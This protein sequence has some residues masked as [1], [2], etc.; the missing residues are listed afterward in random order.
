MSPWS[1]PGLIGSH[2]LWSA[3]HD[4]VLGSLAS[5]PSGLGSDDARARLAALGPNSIHGPRGH[6]GWR[7]LLAQFESPMVLILV[8][9]TLVLMALGGVVDGSVNTAVDAAKQ[10]AAL[11]LLDK[12]LDVVSDAVR[13]GRQTVAN[14]LTYVRVTVSANFGNMLSMAAAISGVGAC[15]ASRSISLPSSCTCAESSLVIDATRA[16]SAEIRWSR[17][18]AAAVTSERSVVRRTSSVRSDSTSARSAS[19]SSADAFGD[20]GK[21]GMGDRRASGTTNVRTLPV[22]LPW[23][24]RLATVPVNRRGVEQ[25]GSSSGS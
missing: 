20:L 16:S 5:T 9:A 11:V 10:T 18:F 25:S 22:G 7:L 17:A 6:R 13:L 24:D 21:S 12:D 19:M 4:D 8:V 3:L 2:S 15:A 14:T 1:G 23:R